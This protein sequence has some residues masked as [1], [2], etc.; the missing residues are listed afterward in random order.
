MQRHK[1]IKERILDK[2]S[3]YGVLMIVISFVLVFIFINQTINIRETMVNTQATV[4]YIGI[5]KDSSKLLN[6]SKKQNIKVEYEYNGKVYEKFLRNVDVNETL[7][8]GDTILIS[9]NS[10]KPEIISTSTSGYANI[11]F[12]IFAGILLLMGLFTIFIYY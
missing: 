2:S 1:A 4:K 8:E 7:A 11:L 5:V 12:I 6:I 3:L 9:I 10:S